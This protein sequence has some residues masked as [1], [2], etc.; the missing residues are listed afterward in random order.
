MKATLS[1]ICRFWRNVFEPN[2]HDTIDNTFKTMY[3]SFPYFG[4]QSEKLT[5]ELHALIRKYFLNTECKI[6]LVNKCTVGSYFN[7]KDKPHAGMRP[8]LVYKFCCAQ[9]ASTFIVSTGHML[10]TRVAEHAGRSYRTGVR[11]AHPRIRPSASAEGCDVGVV[12][13]NFSILN[14][15]SSLLDHHILEYLYI[16]RHK[17]NLNHTQ[18]CFPLEIVNSWLFRF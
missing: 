16:F 12:L 7:C 9:C 5:D 8:S 1:H 6:V 10:R 11:L 2:V 4:S 15:T 18:S 17:P 13:D 14:S 3:F